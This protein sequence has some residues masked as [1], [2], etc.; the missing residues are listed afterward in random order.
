MSARPCVTLLI[1]QTALN[2]LYKTRVVFVCVCVF[3]SSSLFFLKRFYTHPPPP[4]PHNYCTITKRPLFYNFFFFQIKY[5]HDANP[6]PLNWQRS[7]VAVPVLNCYCCVCI[8]GGSLRVSQQI[9]QSTEICIH[10]TNTR[11][12]THTSY[13][14]VTYIKE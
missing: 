6:M 3:S 8:D 7:V 12:H 9:I 14:D 4:Q 1:T 5:I 11:T 10:C 2:E 13:A